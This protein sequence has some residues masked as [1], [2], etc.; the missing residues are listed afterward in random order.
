MSFAGGGEATATGFKTQYDI[1]KPPF[2]PREPIAR[3][4]EAVT[5]SCYNKAMLGLVAG[6]PPIHIRCSHSVAADCAP[7]RRAR[8]RRRRLR[9]RHHTRRPAGGADGHAGPDAEGSAAPRLP[10]QG[11]AALR[12]VRALLVG[13]AGA[14]RR[15]VREQARLYFGETMSKAKGMARTF[16]GFSI[17]YGGSEGIIEKYRGKHDLINATLGGVVT[18]A[19]MA[20]RN[21]PAAMAG[22]AVFI[23]AFSFAIDYYMEVSSRTPAECAHKSLKRL[24]CA[25]AEL[26]PRGRG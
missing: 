16:A 8:R 18:G 6:A 26:L 12:P 25:F 2:P 10:P 5:E 11:A 22:G 14:D 3:Q 17:L 1:W 24:L 4:I 21:G 23:G 13:P 9:V 15:R 7:A 20:V 19:G